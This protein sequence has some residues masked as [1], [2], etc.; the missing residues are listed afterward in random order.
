MGTF[1]FWTLIVTASAFIVLCV[2]NESGFW[3]TITLYLTIC[4][5]QLFGNLKVFDYIRTRPAR[6]LL[7][8]TV[9]FALGAGWSV[10]KWW[11]HVKESRVMY[12]QKKKEFF[13]LTVDEIM[14]EELRAEWTGFV[15]RNHLKPDPKHE[16]SRILRWMTYWPWSMAW[17]LVNDPVREVF[18]YMYKRLEMIYQKIVDR[19]FGDTDGDLLPAR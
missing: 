12:D 1:W 11:F 17:T 7:V 6:A 14:T 15:R 19:A 9:Y 4:L 2:E 8:L 18:N 10:D 3:A 16:K 13:T 5:L